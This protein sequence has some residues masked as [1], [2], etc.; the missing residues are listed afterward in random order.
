MRGSGRNQE[1][2]EGDAS[3]IRR[4]N[5]SR[6]MSLVKEEQSNRGMMSTGVN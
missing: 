1:E 3:M 2:E 4:I 6:L 5:E